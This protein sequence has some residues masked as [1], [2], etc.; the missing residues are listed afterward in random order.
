MGTPTPTALDKWLVRPLLVAQIVLL[1]LGLDLTLAPALSDRFF[2][3]TIK[4]P[5]TA[6]VLG[7]YYLAAFFLLTVA[8]RGRLWSRV[9]L[10]LPGGIAFSMLAIVATFMHLG[11]FHLHG[12]GTFAKV[13]TWVWIIAYL[14]LPPALLAPVPAQLKRD[15]EGASVREKA[16]MRW[17]SVGMVTVGTV[18]VATGCL[19]FVSPSIAAPH[20]AWALT[21]LT[22]RVLG[23]WTLGLGLVFS[24]AG[25]KGDSRSARPAYIGAGLFAVFGISTMLRFFSNVRWEGFAARVILAFLLSTLVVAIGGLNV[26]TDLARE[27]VEI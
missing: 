5:I 18:M 17:S 13:V 7:A 3:W 2:S 19:L 4:P 26:R 9:K 24:M 1:A 22:A 12:A 16:N 20:W 8:M 21:P 11:K 27:S 23:A 10:I 25:M 15:R 14:A 6:G